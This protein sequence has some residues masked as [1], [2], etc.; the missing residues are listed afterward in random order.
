MES[1][2]FQKNKPFQVGANGYYSM[3][4]DY[5]IAIKYGVISKKFIEL[6][7]RNPKIDFAQEYEGAFTSTYNAALPQL[8]DSNFTVDTED[9]FEML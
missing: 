3:F 2:N 5:K 8:E 7:K 1:T 9:E 6:E 4:Y